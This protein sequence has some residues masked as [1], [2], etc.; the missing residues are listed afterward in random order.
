MNY[1]D[2]E[3]EYEDQLPDDLGHYNLM[4]K[5]SKIIDGVRMFPYVR[6]NGVRF[7]LQ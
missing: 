6:I 2:V 4:Y 3:W 7:Y 1:I 5:F